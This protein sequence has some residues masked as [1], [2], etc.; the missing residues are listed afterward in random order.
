[1]NDIFVLLPP[2]DHSKF[3][4]CRKMHIKVFKYNHI[5]ETDKRLLYDLICRVW[6]DTT[7]L[8]I[9][10]K[11]MNATSFCA[12]EENR[13]IG[14]AG[15]VSWD[16]RIHGRPFRMCGLSCVCT[17]PEHRSSGIGSAL[18]KQAT[19][20]ILRNG[21]FDVGLFTCSQENTS[22]YEHIGLW[23]KAKNLVLMESH[24]ANAYRSDFMH[25]NVF[26][27]LLSPKAKQYAEYFDNSII[28]LN[29]PQGRF[30]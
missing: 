25:L 15:V 30:I 19:E 10:H 12:V 7:N 1:M 27:L 6:E 13:F 26:R 9:H 14:Y 8:D 20:Y 23:E 3:I 22:F 11:D 17:H 18:V 21:T 2:L 16:I 29:F 28:N 4:R 24:R 5:S